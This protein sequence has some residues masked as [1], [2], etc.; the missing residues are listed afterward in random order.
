[1]NNSVLVQHFEDED[2]FYDDSLNHSVLIVDLVEV[3]D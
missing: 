2:H 1:M 3:L